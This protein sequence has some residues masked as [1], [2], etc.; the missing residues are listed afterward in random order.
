MAA[1]YEDMGKFNESYKVLQDMLKSPVK[2]LES[3]VYLDLG[4]IHLKRGEK[5]KAKTTFQYVI[6]NGKSGD[7]VVKMARLYMSNMELNNLK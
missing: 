1:L 3:K 2:L 6:D 4:R 5:E 7:D